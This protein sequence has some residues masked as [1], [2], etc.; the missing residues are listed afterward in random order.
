MVTA[1]QTL[2]LIDRESRT[3]TPVPDSLRASIRALEG[4]DLAE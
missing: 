3:A 4:D 1:T 2:V